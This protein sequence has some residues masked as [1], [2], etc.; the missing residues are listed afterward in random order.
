VGDSNTI[1]TT[2]N[3]GAYTATSCVGAARP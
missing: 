3:S 2:Y 1:T